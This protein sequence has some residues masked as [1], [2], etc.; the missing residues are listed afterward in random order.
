MKSPKTSSDGKLAH[1]IDRIKKKVLRFEDIMLFHAL[2]DLNQH[3]DNHANGASR[4]SE[5]ISRKSEE[6][7][8]QAIP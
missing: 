5:G 2:R 6:I 3:V 8:F 4:L 7:V 1:L